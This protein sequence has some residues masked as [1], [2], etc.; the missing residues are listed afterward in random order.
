MKK[1]KFKL[2]GL[3]KVREFKEEEA[4]RLL[5]ETIKDIE[6]AKAEI[7]K[8][9]NEISESFSKMSKSISSATE[10]KLA[11]FYPRYIKRLQD[12]LERNENLLFALNVKLAERRKDL[13][14]AMADVDLLE[15]F[16]N[17]KTTEH[18]KYYE[19]KEN[20]E[21]EDALRIRRAYEGGL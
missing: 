2:D 11:T 10:L 8:N 9:K 4:K 14:K 17:K 7:E 21:I 15:K 3:L 12:D 18:K 19:K 1:F 20:L 16:K 6:N 5:G 13:A